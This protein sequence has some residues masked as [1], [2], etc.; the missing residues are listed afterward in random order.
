MRVDTHIKT[1]VDIWCP[2]AVKSIRK[3]PGESWNS[4]LG[5]ICRVLRRLPGPAPLPRPGR[6]IQNGVFIGI[7][8]EG[9]CSREVDVHKGP[10]PGRRRR[11]L[12]AKEAPDRAGEPGL[13]VDGGVDGGLELVE[14][15]A[16]LLAGHHALCYRLAERL[17]EG[18]AVR[19][20]RDPGRDEPVAVRPPLVLEGD[21]DG[22][23]DDGWLFASH[24]PG[25]GWEVWLCFEQEAPHVLAIATPYVSPRSIH[26]SRA[27]DH[28]SPIQCAIY[29]IDGYTGLGPRQEAT[30]PMLAMLELQP[31]DSE[32][33]VLGHGRADP[34]LR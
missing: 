24:A 4:A 8:V 15:R 16:V 31:V 13:R 20:A 34:I 22:G 30:G 32:A 27:G 6:V 14:V 18:V 17:G 25:Y 26:S 2:I 23:R 29:S 12:G 10:P 1:T 5:P 21:V 19:V 28:I 9:V 33:P 11:G 3:R 7:R